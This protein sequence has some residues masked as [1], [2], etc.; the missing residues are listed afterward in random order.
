MVVLL[1]VPFP[2]IFNISQN[3]GA[4]ICDCFIGAPGGEGEWQVLVSRNLN[5]WEI[6]EYEKL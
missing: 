3:R 6:S 1:K 2:Q 5:D 4:K